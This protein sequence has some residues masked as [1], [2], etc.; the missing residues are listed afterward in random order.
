MDVM[1]VKLNLYWCKVMGE[2]WREGEIDGGGDG[3]WGKICFLFKVKETLIVNMT[4]RQTTLLCSAL[5]FSL[6]V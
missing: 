3:D 1:G 5:S 4:P 2:R 6:S